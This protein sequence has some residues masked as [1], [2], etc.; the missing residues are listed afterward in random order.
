MELVYILVRMEGLIH[1]RTLVRLCRGQ[2]VVV[3]VRI[4]ELTLPM[5]T[6]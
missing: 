3:E 6:H 5:S 4:S 1:Q 2:R